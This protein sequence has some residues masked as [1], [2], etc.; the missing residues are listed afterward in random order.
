MHYRYVVARSAV[1][2]SAQLGCRLA[3]HTRAFLRVTRAFLRVTRAFLRVARACVTWID[4]GSGHN[5][6]AVQTLY[7][8]KVTGV[9][10]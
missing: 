1:S 7:L 6:L 5:K 3:T 9:L 4:L 2:G 10:K 8:F